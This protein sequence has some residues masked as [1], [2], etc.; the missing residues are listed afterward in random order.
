MWDTN[1]TSERTQKHLSG[2]G[3]V[4]WCLASSSWQSCHL[5]THRAP[6]RELTT[7]AVQHCGDVHLGFLVCLWVTVCISH[8]CVHICLRVCAWG[9]LWWRPPVV[10]GEVLQ[11]Q[12]EA[13]IQPLTL[14]QRNLTHTHKCR[15]DQSDTR[16]F[17]CCDLCD[18]IFLTSRFGAIQIQYQQ[19]QKNI[20]IWMKTRHFQ[21][22]VTFSE[23]SVPL[24]LTCSS[25]SSNASCGAAFTRRKWAMSRAKS[26]AQHTH[27]FWRAQTHNRQVC[28]AL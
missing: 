21:R 7:A 27:R 14:F 15:Q 24:I 8:L 6:Y 17:A 28:G 25:S 12:G 18:V 11:G 13:L 16:F 2:L 4:R 23:P 20:S 19:Y 10:Q 5:S 1:G 9:C 3:R 22:R 26:Y